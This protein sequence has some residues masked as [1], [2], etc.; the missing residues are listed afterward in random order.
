[1]K[2]IKVLIADDHAIVRKG[3]GFILGQ[4][5]D[6]E[7]VGEAEDGREAISLTQE[8][9]PDIVL[10]DISMPRLN[11]LEA[12]RR[13]KK[14]L[15]EIKVIVLSMYNDEEY[16]FKILKA[17]SSGYVLKQSAPRELITAIHE[18][19]KGNSFLS[20]PIS[21][22]LIEKWMQNEET[23]ANGDLYDTLSDREKE[24]LQ[25]IAEGLTNREMS[26]ELNLSVKTIETHRSTLMRKLNISHTA[27][28]TRYAIIKGI[29]E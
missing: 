20:P 27:G 3:I 10:M 17:G 22:K 21:S 29:I 25:L 23:A 15:P 28:L 2:T 24:V 11:G 1:M 14:A 4:E 26:R 13:I 16:V 12:T 8:I 7:V 5:W 18:V 9:K 6:I 19:Y